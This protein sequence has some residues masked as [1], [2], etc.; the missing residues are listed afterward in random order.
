[1]DI[2]F[3]KATLPGDLD[4]L[5]EFDH[6]TF[7][8]YPDDLFEREDWSGCVSYWMFVNGIKVGCSAFQHNVDYD[9]APRSGCLYIASTG[10][11]PEFQG[12]GFGK[13]EKQWQIEYAHRNG[14]AMMVTNM[15][16]S[17]TRIIRLNRSLGFRYR[18]LDAAYYHNPDE[19][20]VVMELSLKADG[21]SSLRDDRE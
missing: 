5:L 21:P 16:Q 7:G 13:K 20:A 8:A 2:K 11:L 10:I 12:R 3:Q 15:R 14:F 18:G 6:R 9:G 1:M 17:N 19:P 4:D